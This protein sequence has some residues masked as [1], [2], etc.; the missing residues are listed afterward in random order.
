MP[1]MSI[2]QWKKKTGIGKPKKASNTRKRKEMFKLLGL[3][4]FSSE[5]YNLGSFQTEAKAQ[6]AAQK[7]LRESEKLQPTS[8]SGGQAGIQDQVHI[9]R[10]DGTSYRVFPKM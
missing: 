8:S 6:A 7:K 9:E 5:W 4:T 1:W 3:D 10:P 2:N